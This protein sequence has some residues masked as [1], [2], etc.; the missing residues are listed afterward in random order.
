V[1]EHDQKKISGAS[2]RIAAPHFPSRL[3]PPT[4][5]LVPAS[6]DGTGR[7]MPTSTMTAGFVDRESW[8]LAEGRQPGRPVQVHGRTVIRWLQA[9]KICAAAREASAGGGVAQWYD[10]SDLSG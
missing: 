6:L 9:W 10:H 8:R 3:V 1:E 2:R 7:Q 4:F 5:K